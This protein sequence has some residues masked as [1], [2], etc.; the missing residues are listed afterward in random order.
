MKKNFTLN[1]HWSVRIKFDLYKMDRWTNEK[2]YLIVNG[3][4]QYSKVFTEFE[5]TDNF[6][7]GWAEYPE[8]VQHV[9]VNFTHSDLL[10]QLEFGSTLNDI[11]KAESWGIKNLQIFA[12]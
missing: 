11:F 4:E 5:S 2:F 3:I 12:D 6:M 10:M 7:C 9:D 1:P 8:S